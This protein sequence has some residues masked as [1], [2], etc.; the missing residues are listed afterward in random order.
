M[1]RAGV[2]VLVILGAGLDSVNVEY[3]TG[4]R[5]PYRG[6][7]VVV[8]VG[9]ADPILITSSIAHGEPLHTGVQ[10][11][12][13]RDVRC[14]PNERGRLIFA[15]EESLVGHL[16]EVAEENRIAR[17]SMGVA[18]A[19]V[20]RLFGLLSRA[21]IRV[22]EGTTPRLDL[23]LAR[24]R[25]VK[26]AVELRLMR[27]AAEVAD[28][29]LEAVAAAFR[30]GVSER[31]LAAVANTT[32]FASGADP[33]SIYP[34]QVAS[35]P[36]AGL[37]NLTPSDRRIETGD[38]CY[39]GVLVR[40][41][42]YLGRIGTGL[43]TGTMSPAMSRLFDANRAMVESGM[44]CVQPGAPVRT[45]AM[46]ARAV[47]E[48]AGVLDESWIVGHGMGLAAYDL[49]VIAEGSLDVFETGMALVF[50]PM[51]AEYGVATANA[52]RV[53]VVT[54]DGCECLS[55]LPL[56]VGYLVPRV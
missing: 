46:A 30:P 47:A 56:D 22:D 12:W 35:G 4:F 40:L 8:I 50:E 36:R 20:E 13:L 7:A 5:N 14:S 33:D 25:S 18:G 41:N 27:Q 53:W 44:A 11:T 51:V 37:R 31:E 26:S 28:R 52:E 1:A 9:D 45:A 48:R 42:A 38:A 17:M 23:E 32:A 15:G 3:L 54:D 29:C 21:G 34:V 6:D 2:D 39:I 24:I 43:V 10:D 49:P 55:R 19:Q 16:R